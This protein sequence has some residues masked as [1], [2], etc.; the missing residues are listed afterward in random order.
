MQGLIEYIE[1]VGRQRFADS[2][3]V[4]PSCVGHWISGR[5]KPT[6]AVVRKIEALTGIP[7]RKIRPDLYE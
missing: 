1:A 3:G 2:I 4:T 7:R 5:R 6:I